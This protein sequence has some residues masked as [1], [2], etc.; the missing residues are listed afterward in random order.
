[1]PMLQR[2]VA[3]A[4]VAV[5]IAATVAA[6]AAQPAT[7]ER[8]TFTVGR[9]SALDVANVAGNVRI[10]A[11]EGDVIVVETM[12][13]LRGDS[14]RDGA[15][16][17]RVEM[18]QVGNRVEV[19]ARGSMSSRSSDVIDI[20]VSVPADAAVIARSVSGH[21]AL[22]GTSGESRLETVSGDVDVA[23]AGNVTLAKSVSGGVTLRDAVSA[24]TLTLSSVSGAIVA[25]G[26]RAGGLEATSVSG[27][28]RLGDV[29]ASRVLAKAIS[30][31]ID[32][33]GALAAGGRFEFTAHSGEVRL[34]LPAAASFD[35]SADTYSGRL[36]SDFPVTLRSTSGGR[37][38]RTIRGVAGNG[39]AQLVV[40]SFSG[41]VTIGRQ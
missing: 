1:M 4:V 13:R 31:D 18:T 32:F 35:L 40:R 12:R 10:S 21:V 25:S 26:I 8:R 34:R 23:K 30:G 11:G 29:T 39:D 2:F 15:S 7:D 20:T 3:R 16:T 9:G 19:R 33:S 5:A 41:S 27:G 6:A 36:T 24:G 14:R 28:V 37:S 38:S 17:V 22:T